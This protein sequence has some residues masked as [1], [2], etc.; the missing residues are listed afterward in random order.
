ME[1]EIKSKNKLVSLPVLDEHPDKLTYYDIK[2]NKTK[3][4]E[5]RQIFIERF[6]NFLFRSEELIHDLLF[7]AKSL[8]I[9]EYFWKF[10][11]FH[12]PCTC[13]VCMNP[14]IV[15]VRDF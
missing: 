9:N 2:K 8:H 15:S 6:V 1:K 13:D 7:I 4:I 12:E 14:S 5:Y 3:I 10:L 11:S